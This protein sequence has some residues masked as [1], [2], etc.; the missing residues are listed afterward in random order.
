MSCAGKLFKLIYTFIHRNVKIITTTRKTDS[1]PLAVQVAE[2]T[3]P[4]S[5]FTPLWFYLLNKY[6]EP[7]SLWLQ[8]PLALCIQF[9]LN[10]GQFY[11]LR[12]PLVL[13]FFSS[14]SLYKL[15]QY[16][17]VYFF[18]FEGSLTYKHRSQFFTNL[19]D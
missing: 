11:S 16:V 13:P 7:F 1:K 3:K 17:F 8:Y 5:T 19:Y 18:H 15:N 6:C 4:L 14:K 9:F 2:I 12:V 10:I